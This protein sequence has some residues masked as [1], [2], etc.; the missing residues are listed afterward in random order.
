GRRAIVLQVGEAL[1]QLL[2]GPGEAVDLLQYSRGRGLVHDLPAAL[3]VLGLVDIVPCQVENALVARVSAARVELLEP[4][5]QVN[6]EPDVAARVAGRVG[7]L[8]V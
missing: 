7:G 1:E 5:P 2:V 3:A 4:Q 8:L 6:R